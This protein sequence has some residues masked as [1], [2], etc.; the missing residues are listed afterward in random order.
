[1][2]DMTDQGHNHN[3]SGVLDRELRPETIDLI[4]QCIDWLEGKVDAKHRWNQETWFYSLDPALNVVSLGVASLE[5]VAIPQRNG[6][7]CGTSCCVAGYVTAVTLDAWSDPPPTNSHGDPAN[8]SLW[9]AEKLQLDAN[10]RTWLFQGNRRREEL[11]WAM[12]DAVEA[13]R[14]PDLR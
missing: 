5:Q 1:M 8:V 10:Q 7:A 3:M 11:V 6:Y 12:R 4:R 13:G 14:W 9:A 2:T